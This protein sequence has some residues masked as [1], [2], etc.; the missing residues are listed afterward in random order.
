ML[1]WDVVACFVI[2]KRVG[3]GVFE[4]LPGDHPLSVFECFMEKKMFLS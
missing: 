4:L 3:V 1:F 2:N